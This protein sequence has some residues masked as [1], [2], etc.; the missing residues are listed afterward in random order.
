MTPSSRAVLGSIYR[1]HVEVDNDELATAANAMTQ[2]AQSGSQ[3]RVRRHLGPRLERA[4][5]DIVSC[6]GHRDGAFPPDKEHT[7]AET[8]EASPPEQYGNP[9]C[10]DVREF[11]GTVTA[12]RDMMLAQ[13]DSNP[14]ALKERFFMVQD[15][16][17]HSQQWSPAWGV[18]EAER[19][20]GAFLL[21]C[22][23]NSQLSQG[24]LLSTACIIAF[25]TSLQHSKVS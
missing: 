23:H 17:E 6:E 19:S 13:E 9:L 5:E 1:T 7:R 24:D 10:M 16:E 4:R 14:K 21:M 25:K 12:I 22:E 3:V 8:S 15:N 2:R 11:E 18:Q 20:D